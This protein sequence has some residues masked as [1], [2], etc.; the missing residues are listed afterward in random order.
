MCSD[1]VVL[2]LCT[3]DIITCFLCRSVAICALAEHM[4]VAF[5]YRVKVLKLHKEWD[6]PNWHDLDLYETY[7]PPVTPVPQSQNAEED[8]C[9]VL[10]GPL[11]LEPYSLHANSET[12]NPEAV[13]EFLSCD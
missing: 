6:L 1:N 4:L 8:G 11:N 13:P 5:G 10:A 7:H 3:Y 2:L 12:L 9:T